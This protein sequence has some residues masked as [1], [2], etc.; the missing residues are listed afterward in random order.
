MANKQR[1]WLFTEI[2]DEKR[3][4]QGNAGYD[5][6]TGV[7]YRYDNSVPNHK[8]PAEGDVVV[9]RRGDEVLGSAVI[10]EIKSKDGEK[11]RRRCPDCGRTKVRFRKT[12]LPPWRCMDCRIDFDEPHILP[13]I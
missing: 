9:L 13:L 1:C 10:F 4:T 3:I 2:E 5:D 8:N 7:I 6:E 12:I 11:E